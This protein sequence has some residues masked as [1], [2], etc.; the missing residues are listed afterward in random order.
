M[1]WTRSTTGLT[2]YVRCEIWNRTTCLY[3]IGQ[4]TDALLL[5]RIA[6]NVRTSMKEWVAY[7]FLWLVYSTCTSLRLGLRL[8]TDPSGPHQLSPRLFTR[9]VYN[10]CLRVP[11]VAYTTSCHKSNLSTNSHGFQWTFDFGFQMWAVVLWVDEF[12]REG[13][14]LFSRY[15]FCTLYTK[16][17][18]FLA[19]N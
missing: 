19:K 6:I 10:I 8:S 18:M 13:V 17:D 14:E 4:L 12:P 1:I 15:R 5:M 16:L 11:R 3:R 7:K 2:E 9:G